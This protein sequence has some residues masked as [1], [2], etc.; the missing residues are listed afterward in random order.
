MANC[1]HNVYFPHGEIKINITSSALSLFPL[2]TQNSCAIIEA[3]QSIPNQEIIYKM[4]KLP[5]SKQTRSP[6]TRGR[7]CHG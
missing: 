5:S 6:K 2:K 4:S 3:S 7:K 1:I